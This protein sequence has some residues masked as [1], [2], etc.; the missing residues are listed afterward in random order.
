MYGDESP[1]GGMLTTEHAAAVI[2]IGAL[3]A[4]IVIR[5]GFRGIAI[6][7]VGGAVIG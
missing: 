1:N 6:P 2:V 7:G 5:K 3:V 4:L